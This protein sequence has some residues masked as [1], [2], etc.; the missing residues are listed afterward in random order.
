MAFDILNQSVNAQVT[1]AYVG[2]FGRAPD[3]AGLNFWI[4]EYNSNVN[5]TLAGNDDPSDA[6]TTAARKTA[7]ANVASSFATDQEGLETYPFLQ[8]PNLATQQ[9]AANFVNEVFN[10]LFNRDAEGTADDPTT[11][12]GFWTQE[13]L[14]RL[15][16]SDPDFIGTVIVDIM[17]GAQ[18][19]DVQ[20]LQNK[21]GVGQ[22]YATAFANAAGE[23]AEW[24]TDDDIGGA[25]A[26]VEGVDETPGS[27]NAAQ[28]QIQQIIDEETGA[29]EPPPSSEVVELT[30]NADDIDGDNASITVF[31]GAVGTLTTGD[32]LDGGTGEGDI[33]DITMKGGENEVAKLSEIEL[34]AVRSLDDGAGTENTL[35]LNDATGVEEVQVIDKGG[36]SAGLA[37]NGFS[38]ASPDIN[39]TGDETIGLKVLDDTGEISDDDANGDEVNVGVNAFDGELNLR[40]GIETVNLEVANSS[41]NAFTLSQTEAGTFEQLIVTDE[42]APTPPDDGKDG[43]NGNGDGNGDGDDKSS[44][45]TPGNTVITSAVA[46]LYDYSGSAGDHTL[47]LT[48][49][50]PS[51]AVTVLGGSGANTVN[52]GRTMNGI[53]DPGGQDTVKGGDGIDEVSAD[54]NLGITVQPAISEV[55]IVSLT[56]SGAD[57]QNGEFDAS[58]VEPFDVDGQQFPVFVVG[59]SE[60]FANINEIRG[61]NPVVEVVGNLEDGA[62]FD[63]TTGTADELTVNF[64][65]DST[66]RTDIKV[67]GGDLEIDDATKVNIQVAPAIAPGGTGTGEGEVYIQ[68]AVFLNDFTEQ[69][70]IATTKEDDPNTDNDGDLIISGEDRDSALTGT[71]AITDLYFEAVN[72]NIFVGDGS[73]ADNADAMDDASSLQ[74]L[75]GTADNAIL[76]VG[77]IGQGEGTA[78]VNLDEVHLQGLNRGVFNFDDIEGVNGDGDDDRAI[79]ASFGQEGAVIE[80]FEVET[81]FRSENDEDFEVDGQSNGFPFDVPNDIDDIS[82]NVI[83]DMRLTIAEFGDLSI[84]EVASSIEE[85]TITNG[86]TDGDDEDGV[87]AGLWMFGE[88][89]QGLGMV[90]TGSEI[91]KEPGYLPFFVEDVEAVNTADL[92]LD[93][94][95]FAG[96]DNR[97]DANFE[98]VVSSILI[99]DQDTI[100]TGVRYDLYEA[101]IE[102]T[103]GDGDHKGT[104]DGDGDEFVFGGQFTGDNA[105]ANLPDFVENSIEDADAFEV[106]GVNHE[107][108]DYFGI[109]TG[110]EDDSIT[111]GSGSSYIFAN[112]GDDTV[113][114]GGGS[115][116][117][118]G[119]LGFNDITLGASPDE[120]ADTHVLKAR[121]KVLF[122]GNLGRMSDDGPSIEFG[123]DLIRDFEAGTGD[124]VTELEGFANRPNRF[125]DS[126]DVAGGPW[127]DDTAAD[128][129]PATVQEVGSEDTA[130]FLGLP[131]VFQPSNEDVEIFEILFETINIDAPDTGPDATS[132]ANIEDSFKANLG[133][134]LEFSNYDDD[135]AFFLAYD[136]DTQTSNSNAALFLVEVGADDEPNGPTPMAGLEIE[137]GFFEGLPIQ[138]ENG[139]G[140]VNLVAVYQDVGFGNMEQ[141]DFLFT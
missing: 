45:S 40:N 50:D 5:D 7:L 112:A 116:L 130:E 92:M 29:I 66:E 57:A 73:V 95:D 141:G 43:G 123:Y 62:E 114:A 132:K 89:V 49:D 10:N 79:N 93:F 84:G 133:D 111:T 12:L 78:A 51:D 67:S 6:E 139:L 65:S 2:F 135:Y 14:D 96:R 81:A 23:G 120:A 122:D 11:G 86:E 83:E 31:Q 41:D 115:D 69:L 36:D 82:A 90:G 3:P 134:N 34:I 33:L 55:E 110:L 124:D 38:A 44:T 101:D 71:A 118:D 87:E 46:S 32:N 53:S 58:D 13:V 88:Q 68:N 18:N 137:P 42:A 54:I 85:L 125:G 27:V 20:A 26:V 91:P 105:N 136:N 94:R 100:G 52:F 98:P 76:S 72:G 15:T 97:R 39:V 56:F 35:N 103:A 140:E 70:R 106:S 25:R 128:G 63:A 75:N 119:G 28:G 117:V 99:G 30:P 126:F 16:N 109:V 129:V 24:T 138:P 102:V 21:I 64:A 1:A 127:D 59:D 60:N 61:A 113:V 131:E 107:E 4:G 48:T 47:N 77:D 22:E 80:K 9:S 104:D 108:Q 37:I 8:T 19:E 74:R 121:D 17:S